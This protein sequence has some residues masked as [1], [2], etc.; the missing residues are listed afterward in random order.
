M[1]LSIPEILGGT[2]IPCLIRDVSCVD[3]IKSPPTT[4]DP[5]FRIGVKA[6]FFFRSRANASTPLLIKGP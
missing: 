6:H 2:I 5:F 4:L 3:P 1:S